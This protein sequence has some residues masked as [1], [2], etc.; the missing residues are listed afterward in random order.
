MEEL[1]LDGTKVQYYQ[2]K[3]EAWE[4]GER[5]SPIT[6]D[7]SLYPR[8]R[9]NFDC[10][11]CYSEKAGQHNKGPGI[12]RRVIT[13]FLEDAAEIGVKGISFVSD[14]ES[15]HHP[16]FAYAIKLGHDLGLDM[17]VGSNA[18]VVGRAMAEQIIPY[19]TYFRVNI[20]AGEAKRFGEIMGVKAAWLERV[21]QNIRDMVDVKR[22]RGSSCTIGTQMVLM[23]E[24]ADQII[25]L[26]Q[27][28]L[29][30]G[31]DY[32]ILKHTS[33]DEFGHIGVDYDGYEALYPLLRKAEAMSTDRTQI[34]VKWN[35]IGNKGIRS[36]SRCYGPPFIL[37][38]S[39]TGLV[40]PCGMLFNQRYKDKFH[41]GN[42]A[43]TRFKEIWQSERY[44]EVVAL[45]ASPAFD[46]KT[47]CG[48]LC[49]QD[50]TNRALDAH[51]K[52]EK[53]IETPAGPPPEHLSFI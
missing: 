46:A 25:P 14:G 32:L 44:W 31:V 28:S 42:I 15:S 35:K 47:M 2:D 30:L 3:V 36:Y 4:R 50:L 19:L 22:V 23:P 13:E 21:C 1:I 27:L 43:E 34:S 51:M 12:D 17:A 40:A 29:D 7:M 48:S 20:S 39:G 11:Y 9:C 37:Q 26:A 33:D 49:L 45:L 5:I 8:N 41:I 18:L 10:G 53:R 6:I 38:L 52:G 16:D 24:Y